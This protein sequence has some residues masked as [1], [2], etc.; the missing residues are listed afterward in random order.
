MKGSEVPMRMRMEG[1]L[2]RSETLTVIAMKGL[3]QTCNLLAVCERKVL[4]NMGGS[5]KVPL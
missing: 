1:G 2:K 5:V 4:I 3:E